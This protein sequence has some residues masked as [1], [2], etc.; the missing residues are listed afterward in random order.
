MNFVSLKFVSLATATLQ[1]ALLSFHCYDFKAEINDCLSVKK[2][3]HRLLLGA[4][5]LPGVYHAP[6]K[7]SSCVSPTET[8]TRPDPGTPPGTKFKPHS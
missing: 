5:F 4:H 6:N 1:Y 7:L 3:Y 2:Y 8:A